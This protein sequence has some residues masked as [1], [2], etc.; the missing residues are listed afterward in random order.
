MLHT[1]Y[2]GSRTGCFRR[3][4]FPYISLVFKTCDPQGHFSTQGHNLNKLSSDPQFML[5]TKYQGSRT[6]CFRR[7]YFPYISLVFK[8]CD[9]QGHF[10]TQGHN[11]NKLSSDPLVYGTYQ[12]SRLWDWLFQTKIFSIYKPSI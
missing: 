2:Q 8:T 7:R 11:L 10:A 9:P 4:Y 1:K 5:H 6:G 3:R 12:I